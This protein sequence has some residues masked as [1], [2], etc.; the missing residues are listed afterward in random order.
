M[1]VTSLI[2]MTGNLILKNKNIKINS[3]MT[4]CNGT[5]QD[6]RVDNIEK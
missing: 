5:V 6:E 2:S 3:N 4:V 1:E